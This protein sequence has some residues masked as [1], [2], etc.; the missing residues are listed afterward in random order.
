[1]TCIGSYFGFGIDKV[2][3]II[4]FLCMGLIIG[5][6]TKILSTLLILLFIY[7]ALI[8]NIFEVKFIYI[9]LLFLFGI[10]IIIKLRMK[11]TKRYPR[12]INLF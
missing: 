2:F 3:F 11:I 1:M 9:V 8:F 4:A 6:N 12:F 10:F 7:I 5:L